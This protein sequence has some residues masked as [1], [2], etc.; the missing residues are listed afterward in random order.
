MK[1]PARPRVEPTSDHEA[2]EKYVSAQASKISIYAFLSVPIQAEIR[3][4]IRSAW[5]A[6]RGHAYEETK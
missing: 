1:R 5:I 2:M 6:G 4:A 3:M